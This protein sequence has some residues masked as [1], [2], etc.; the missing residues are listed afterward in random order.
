VPRLSTPN[1]LALLD[2]RL[3]PTTLIVA[4][5]ADV[6]AEHLARVRSPAKGYMS[7]AFIEDVEL[8]MGIS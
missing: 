8:S 4:N 2:D 6:G 3:R 5:D 1:V 7:V